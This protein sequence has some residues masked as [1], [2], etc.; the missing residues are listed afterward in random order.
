M[1]NPQFDFDNTTIRELLLQAGESTNHLEEILRAVA[2]GIIVQDPKGR[3][4][5]ANQ[6]AASLIGVDSP[7][8]LLSLTSSEILSNFHIYDQA[9][10]LF[11]TAMLPGRKALAGQECSDVVIRSVNKSNRSEKWTQIKATPI[12]DQAGRVLFAVNIF[13]DL[14]KQKETEDNLNR[15]IRRNRHILESITDGFYALDRDLNVTFINKQAEPF[16]YN[17]DVIGKNIKDIYPDLDQKGPKFKERLNGALETNTTVHF[18]EYY[19]TLKKWLQFSMYPSKDGISVYFRDIT[20]LKI[21]SLSNS[22][23]GAIVE[24][25]DDAIIGKGLDGIIRSWNK[26]AVQI[27]GYKPEE[28]IGKHISTLVPPGNVDDTQMILDKIN[29]GQSIEHYQTQRLTKD[30]RVID[31]SVT[32]SPIRDATGAIIGASAVAR[33]ITALKNTAEIQ[34]FLYDAG[35]LLSSSLDYETTLSRVARSVVPKFADWCGIEILTPTG[36]TKQVAVEH[37]DPNKIQFALE[38]GQKY[39]ADKDTDQGIWRVLR[40]GESQIYPIITDEM[41][42]ASSKSEDHYRLVSTL[43][44][45]SVIIVP[46]AARHKIFGALTLIWAESNKSYSQQDLLFAEE[47]GKRAGAAIDNALLYKEAQTEIQERKFVEQKLQISEERYRALI[48]N[49]SDGVALLTAEGTLSFVTKP[50]ERM[51]GYVES[52]LLG[53]TVFDFIH[54]DDRER[55][56]EL[57]ELV[58]DQSGLPITAQ[59]RC[60]HRTGSYKW[61]ECVCVNQLEH[62]NIKSVIAN[63]RDITERKRAEEN[64]QYQYHHDTL[65]DLPNRTY[66]NEKFA[67]NIIESEKK[68]QSLGLMLID[69]DRFKQ[70]N[71]SLGHALGDRLIQAVALR[72]RSCVKDDHILAR[73]G[74]DEFGILVPDVRLEQDAAKLANQIIEDFRPPFYLDNH[75]IY[76]SPSIGIS[77]YPYDGTESATLFKNA[78]TALYRAKEHGRNTYQFYTTTMNAAAYERLTLESKLRHAIDNDEFV[79]FYQPQIDVMNGKIVGTEGLIRWQRPDMSL[80][81]PDRFIPLAEANGLIEP[82]GEWVVRTALQQGKI[83][84]DQGF[85]LFIAINLSARQFKQKNFENI[86]IRMIEESKLDPAFIEF[87]LTESMFAE[88]PEH[89]MNIMNALRQRGVRFCLDDFSTG[90]SSLKYI[91]QFP[92]DMI[93]IERNFMK[94]IP[95]DVQNSAIAKSIITLGKSLGMEVTAEGVESKQQLAFLYDNACNRAQGY[96]FNGGMPAHS[97][98][99]ILGEDRYVSVVSSLPKTR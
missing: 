13:H 69:L 64:L 26:G 63:F 21:R 27:Y 39:P 30:N 57:F 72:I 99:E 19:P 52:E 65:T 96:L 16:F 49:T 12:K 55:V 5:F 87:E 93:K 78:E 46:L 34:Q 68:R 82:I 60:R 58:K 80:T 33:D 70:I 20:E 59:Y 9:G 15:I 48:E 77:L 98:S 41:I 83:W 86:L 61:I 51:L 92:V 45:H 91:K 36:E 38:L 2:D 17:Q 7:Q 8:A 90:Y 85:K 84:H 18:E 42:K 3:I 50:I 75:E 56:L 94:G 1:D 14:T 22:E 73:L 62:P 25:S 10:Q 31:V 37:I 76:I 23:L 88:N 79:L 35:S 89:V 4:I 29:L 11:D 97:L 40:T 44:L 53:Q 81:L 74:G 67:D 54:S 71:E 32:I 28:I 24:S 95:L 66:L 6:A 43:G 47:L